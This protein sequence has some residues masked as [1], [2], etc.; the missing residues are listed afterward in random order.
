[1]AKIAAILAREILDSR[2]IPTIEAVASLDDGTSATAAVP[3]GT[4]IGRYEAEELRDNDQTR[5]QGMGVLRAVEN[6]NKVIAPKIQGLDPQNQTAL[7]AILIKLD[8]SPNKKNLGANAILAVSLATCRAASISAKIPLYKHINNLAFNI[9]LPTS[10]ENLPTPIFNL[11]NG[12]K[13]GAGN[14]NFQEFHVVPA[15]NKPYS[16]ALRIGQ[17]IYQILGRVLTYRGAVHS[18]GD[19]GGYAPNL[20][21]NID[22]LD[23][24]RDTVGQTSYQL[25]YDLFL[26]LDV[27][28]SVFKTGRG[29]QLKD[30]EEPYSGEELIVYYQ[31]LQIKYNLLLLEDPFSEDDWEMWKKLTQSLGSQTIVVGDDLLATNKERLKRA[32]EEKAATAILVKPN[33][34]GTLTETLAVV[35]MAR[36]ANFKVVVSHRS[37]ETND[38]FIADFA[39]GVAADY[40]KFGAP[41]RGERVAKYNRLSEIEGE[42]GK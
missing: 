19:E 24:L 37:G 32:I 38:A 25:G 12:G 33:Q 6:V 1:M 22:A 10:G 21:T 16:D 29:Y 31:G 20:F 3:A 27:A 36:A 28:A 26:G 41:A 7:D 8:G 40:V 14:L 42:L 11:I 30:R 5:F 4:S 2:G 35:K 9:N 13:H 18:V 39:V 34:I 15:T 23:I 17:E